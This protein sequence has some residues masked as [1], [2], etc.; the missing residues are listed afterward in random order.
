M[1]NAGQK[2]RLLGFGRP[3]PMTSDDD[4]SPVDAEWLIEDVTAKLLLRAIG[5]ARSITPEWERKGFF[6][7][8]KADDIR[9]LVRVRRPPNSIRLD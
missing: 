3:R 2:I 6:R 4:V 8:Q 9:D 7:D 1:R 5:G